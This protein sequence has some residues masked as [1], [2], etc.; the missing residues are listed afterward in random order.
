MYDDRS[1]A[2]A[3]AAAGGGRQEINIFLRLKI[4]KEEASAK[5]SAAIR[6]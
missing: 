3:A 1:V 6:A 2:A 4:R 5:Q